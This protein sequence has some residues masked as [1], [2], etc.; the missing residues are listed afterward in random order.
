MD[1]PLYYRYEL[2]QVDES[3]VR[4]HKVGYGYFGARPSTK[5]TLPRSLRANDSIHGSAFKR[6][7][8]PTKVRCLFMYIVHGG[9]QRH[10]R[11]AC[12]ADLSR[13][14]NLTRYAQRWMM[15]DSGGGY[16]SLQR[17]TCMCLP[18]TSSLPMHSPSALIGLPKS[19]MQTS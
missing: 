14:V 11:L 8:D 9:T 3:K 18:V 10:F 17:A 16:L 4:A 6:L 1:N 2:A 19:T 15:T 7:Q 13:S 5:R 12:T